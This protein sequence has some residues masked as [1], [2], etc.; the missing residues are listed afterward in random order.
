MKHSTSGV[1]VTGFLR[2]CSS[3]IVALSRFVMVLHRFWKGEK[4]QKI[5]KREIISQSLSPLNLAAKEAIN[6][7]IHA[8]TSVLEECTISKEEKKLNKWKS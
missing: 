3:S 2:I 6:F 4:R 1:L 8:K 5:M 7:I